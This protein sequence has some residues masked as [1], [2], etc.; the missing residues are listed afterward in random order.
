ML[1]DIIFSLI[2]LMVVIVYLA[3]QENFSFQFLKNQFLLVLISYIFLI[4]LPFFIFLE[5]IH[6]NISNTIE[7]YIHEFHSNVLV[8]FMTIDI[9]IFSI[10]TI[11]WCISMMYTSLFVSQLAIFFVNRDLTRF[12]SFDIKV[13]EKLS[14]N[15][16]S[17]LNKYKIA[18][19]VISTER[20]GK[21]FSL[22]YFKN[23]KK[24]NVIYLSS[25]NFDILTNDEIN[26]AITHEI[27]HIKNQDTIY[28]PIFNTISR[29]MFF[30]PIIQKIRRNYLHKIETRADS[31][32]I[33]LCDPKYLADAIIK[34]SAS[35]DYNPTGSGLN[36]TTFMPRN[37]EQQFLKSRI[38][39][40]LSQK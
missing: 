19:K 24:Q 23:F 6:F 8:T 38:N 34:T 20:F 15:T 30:E 17:I 18:V 16:L 37:S 26:A 28:S 25:K 4:F 36:D 27:A 40:I 33:G 32:A 35:Y 10:I 39:R 9:D 22:T 29:F 21:I 2:P 13:N 3:M 31:F 11:I 7:L 14:S 5:M 1:S 12:E